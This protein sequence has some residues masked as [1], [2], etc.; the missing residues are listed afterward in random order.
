MT[1]SILTVDDSASIRQALK[2][3]LSSAGY[4]VEDAD[5]GQE[6]L[7]KAESGNYDMIITDLN[8]PVMDGLSMIREI[9]ARQA[10]VGVPIVFL[11]TE[12]DDDMKAQA[13]SAGWLQSSSSATSTASFSACKS[14]QI[15]SM[16]VKA[17]SVTRQRRV[18]CSPR[19]AA[20]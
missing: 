2:L 12:S 1:A 18:A 11:T 17:F 6:G 20:R 9:R 16:A 5:N 7:R 3:T 13:R 15:C 10:A 8:M 19:V 4:T 14:S